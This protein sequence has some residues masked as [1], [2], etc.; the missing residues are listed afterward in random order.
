MTDS[1]PG[2]L[3]LADGWVIA[4]G[5]ESLKLVDVSRA[6]PDEIVI[7]DLAQVEAL[8][9][10]VLGLSQGIDRALIERGRTEGL[11]VEGPPRADAVLRER[12]RRL[13]ALYL[14]PAAQGLSPRVQEA[15]EKTLEAHA[16]RKRFFTAV[17]QC[18]VLP[19]TALR[20][21][22]LVGDAAEVG[23]KD[24]L[25]IGDDDLVS[26][27]L[28]ALGHRV[29]VFDIDDYLLGFLRI[30]RE[31][32]QLDIQLEEVNLLDPLPGGAEARFD[33]F[34]TD[35]MSNRQ[36]FE[37]FLSRAFAL[38]RP[39]GEG[40]VAVFPPTTSLFRD[41]AKDMGFR[42]ESWHRRHNRYYSHFIQLH[43][44]ESDWLH[45]R[46]GDAVTLRPG[47]QE[48]C[49]ATN[50]YREAVF[51]R[52]ATAFGFYD[53]IEDGHFTKPLFFDLLLDAFE[54]DIDEAVTER[55]L[56]S[57]E[58]W[59]LAHMLTAVGHIT[60]HADRVRKQ[61]GVE[62]SPMR[63][64]LDDRLRRLLIAGYKPLATSAKATSSPYRWDVR[65]W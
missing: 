45:V 46:P 55:T 11:L 56:R 40:Y 29:T 63:P 23:V 4:V 7:D 58:H 20:R 14:D 13:D 16:W 49:T 2:A 53:M 42:I 35:P 61:I 32:L 52:Q 15:Y 12:L 22:L 34:L 62:I 19:E 1:T 10:M 57:G 27:T 39:Q 59:T 31:Q 44:Y 5:R 41:V 6:D 24:V 25:C 43:R 30:L 26:V 8:E 9:A 51:E 33:V 21:A 65:V 50:L 60:V 54:Q 28:A 64:A 18:P 37:L 3:H 38:L 17:G 47:P 48:Y 36:C